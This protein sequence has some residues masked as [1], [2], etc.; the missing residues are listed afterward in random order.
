M[1]AALLVED[2]GPGALGAS[3]D[4]FE[5]IRI[6]KVLTVRDVFRVAGTERQKQLTQKQ[7][8]MVRDLN[9][10]AAQEARGDAE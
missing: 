10:L 9:R 4:F 8:E 7:W 1:Q 3:P 2:F 6:R 5:L